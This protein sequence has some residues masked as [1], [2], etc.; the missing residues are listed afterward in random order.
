LFALD[1]GQP[2]IVA[3]EVRNTVKIGANGRGGEVAPLQ[4]LK[5]ELT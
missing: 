5:H 4:L 1:L 3:A 2:A